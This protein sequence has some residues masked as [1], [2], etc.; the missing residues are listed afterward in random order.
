MDAFL[1]RDRPLVVT[2]LFL[3]LSGCPDSGSNSQGMILHSETFSDEVQDSI[4]VYRNGDRKPV[5]FYSQK[6]VDDDEG[7]E[8]FNLWPHTPGEI[9]LFRAFHGANSEVKL[10]FQPNQDKNLILSLKTLNGAVESLTIRSASSSNRQL[11]YVDIDADG[12]FDALLDGPVPHLLIGNCWTKSSTEWKSIS[13]GVAT[14]VEG[15]Y[16]FK[17]GKW[18]RN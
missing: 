5:A 11:V 8:S 12:R 4:T 16:R 13:D 15:I 2:L 3:S 10:L 17:D 14:C 18:T 1:R 7:T 6:F 9:T